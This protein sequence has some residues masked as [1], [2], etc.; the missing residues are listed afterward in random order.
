MVS[1]FLPTTVRCSKPSSNRSH[2][3]STRTSP[4]SLTAGHLRTERRGSP[5]NTWKASEL[6]RIASANHCLST[7]GSRIFLGVCDAVRYAHSKGVIHR[8]LKPSNILVTPEGSVKLL[9]FGIAKQMSEGVDGPASTKTGLNPLTRAYSAPEQFSRGEVSSETDVY[10]LGVILH[11]LL[12]GELPSTAEAVKD[13]I[14]FQSGEPKEPS[15]VSSRPPG[16]AKRHWADLGAVIL[17]AIHRDVAARYR[18][19]DALMQDI[20]RFLNDEPLEVRPRSASYWA[21]KFVRRNRTFFSFVAAM[22]AVGIGL[23]T[24]Y[25]I[26]LAKARDTAVRQAS[27]ADHTKELLLRILGG[28]EA[29]APSANLRVI[30]VLDNTLKRAHEMNNE[31][32]VQA[33]LYETIGNVYHGLG[34]LDKAD[35]ALQLAIATRRSLQ[36]KDKI[37]SGAAV[38]SLA[39]VRIDQARFAEAEQLA[40]GEI[41]LAKQRLPATHKLLG[42]SMAALGSALQRDGRDGHLSEAIDI[43]QKAVQLENGRPE[44]R[45]QFVDALGFLGNAYL[46]SGRQAAAEPLERRVLEEDRRLYGDRSPAVAEDLANLSQVQIKRGAYTEAEQN[47][48]EAL[49]IDQGWYRHENVEVALLEEGLAESLIYVGKFEEASR[50][51]AS[52]MHAL[53][54]E[55]GRN[56]PFFAYGLNIS[57]TLAL[58]RGDLKEAR[59][60][61][62]EMQKVYTAVFG[63]NDRHFALGLLRMGELYVAENDLSNAEVAFRQSVE[64]MI[65]AYGPII[66]RPGLHE[67]S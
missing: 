53:Q 36:G 13:E 60:D 31:P 27:R 35:S 64:K 28:S 2:G 50:F 62:S 55:T 63:G 37:D 4:A 61:F 58:R 49:A 44:E 56:H 48:R 20:Q 9:D 17:K 19:V 65:A 47:A 10:A 25:T 8:D 26:R 15:V 51:V 34:D 24:F 43:L 14:N 21:G 1:G 5:W 54:S 18:T 33:D 66:R 32:E 45:S 3:S 39:M 46:I 12:T 22:L 40:R 30:D 59:S 52:G 23:T 57:G 42:E 16:L 41:E 67:S 29:E 11:E 7:I 6:P 38:I